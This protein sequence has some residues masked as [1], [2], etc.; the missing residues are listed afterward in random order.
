MLA[1]FQPPPP[2]GA[3]KPLDWSRR[4]YATQLLGESFELEFFE[5][6]SPLVGESPEAIWEL[7][8]A[9][10]GPIKALAASLEEQR[11]DELHNAFVDY[12][13]GHLTDDGTVSAPREYLLIIGRNKRG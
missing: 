6:E 9:A 10:F 7:F 8:L 3:G 12:L 5:G 1:G 4:E 2:E 11:R 13:S